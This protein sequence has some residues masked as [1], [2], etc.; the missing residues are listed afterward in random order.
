MR[1]G[2]VLS[3]TSDPYLLGVFPPVAAAG[4]YVQLEPIGYNADRMAPIS[5]TV[6]LHWQPGMHQ[7]RLD[8]PAGKTDPVSLL[9][10]ELAWH[11]AGG[12]NCTME[13]AEP[14]A[15]GT[16]ITG[17]L[18]APNDVHLF[19]F[20]AKAEEAFS[21]E[22]TAR[23][24]GS[25]LDCCLDLLDASGH[26][27]AANDDADDPVLQRMNVAAVLS[28]A[29]TRDSRLTWTAPADGK[30]WLRVR[31]LHGRGGTSYF[32]FLA[33][34]PV[35]PDFTLQCDDDKA[36][37]APGTHRTWYVKAQRRNGLTGAIALRVRGLPRGITATCA[38]I[39]PCM[40][41]GAVILSADWDAPRDAR[42]VEVVGTACVTMADGSER[43]LEQV[44]Q[45]LQEIYLPG[46]YRGLYGVQLHTVAVTEPADL[47]LLEPSRRELH[48]RP[49]Q[50]ARIDINLKRNACY[51][52]H[53]TLDAGLRHLDLV[54][55]DPLPPG[56]S[57]D[58]KSSKLRLEA[59]ET[60]GHI[61]LKAAENA[62][63]V[64][65][66]PISIQGSVFVNLVVE[67]RHSTPPILLTVGPQEKPADA[68]SFPRSGSSA[69]AFGL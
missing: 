28:R 36:M 31:D 57:V 61:V 63:S 67:M 13:T 1:W 53:V 26:E 65:D 45:P 68:T 38:T 21:F 47:L 55:G 60:R 34:R 62:T 42:T 37:L 49:G 32:Y 11:L 9:V 50:S 59:G 10:T 5:W 15:R 29:V 39:P 16:G 40:T 44:A 3:I 52:K 20:D 48:L 27:L 41:Q 66:L 51:T 14:I 30:Y 7:V 17:R 33:V 4:E 64:C 58:E 12:D 69:S 56:I 35:Q 8:G 6:P 43:E 2:Y 18:A 54:Y 24:L 22:I 23:P 19:V 25:A 46:A